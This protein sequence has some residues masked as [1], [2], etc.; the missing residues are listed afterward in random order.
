MVPRG[1]AA[2]TDYRTV[3]AA[4][5]LSL[6]A[7]HLHTGRTHQIR[8]HAKHLGHPLVGDP[9]YGEA[10]WKILERSRQGFVRDFPRPA[11]HAWRLAFA[12]P[13]TGA[14]LAFEAPVPE[15]LRALWREA[16]ETG[17]PSP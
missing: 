4:A 10:R 9:V 8:V 7:F 16:T 13:K 2:H 6:L 15:D 1:R 14:S 5:G 12:H 11:L 3:A 17:W